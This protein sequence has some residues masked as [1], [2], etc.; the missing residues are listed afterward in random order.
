M[1]KFDNIPGEKDRNT[2]ELILDAAKRVFLT[3]GFDG[4]RMQDIADS[5]GLNKALIYYYFRSKENLYRLVVKEIME[6]F[7][8]ALFEV[9]YS[10]AN[11][12]DKIY[13]FFDLYISFLIEN[14]VIPQFIIAELVRQPD[15]LNEFFSKP[16]EYGAFQRLSQ[17]IEDS[18]Q[19]KEMRPISP[20][21]FL[22]NLISLSVFPV[23]TRSIFMNFFDV[24]EE[25]YD[26]LIAERKQLAAEFFLRAIQ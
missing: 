16:M 17:L 20:Q 13:T 3:R 11:L 15:R 19:K 7:F 1:T 9:F 8:P 26:K 2:E 12:S 21:H 24:D 4:A 25:H 10:K 14:P 18:V 23:V 5:A 22:I 6:K